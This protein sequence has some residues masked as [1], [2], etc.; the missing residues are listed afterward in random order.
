[1]AI[2]P[3]TDL[4]L[5]KVPINIDNQNQLTFAS[6]AAQYTYFNSLNK[7]EVDNFTYQ[8][9][10]GI[11]RYPAHIDSI[12]NY[13]YC[14]YQNSNY[15][16][17]WF[18]A[19]ITGM[20]YI[21][22]NMTEIAISTDVFQTWCFDIDVKT[23]YVEREHV[24][25]DS[26]GIHTIPE[27]LELGEYIVDNKI[28]RNLTS[29]NIIIGTTVDIDQPSSHSGK[30]PNIIGDIIGGV[31]TGV[32]YYEM[33]DTVANVVLER[34]A[35]KGQSDAVVT[36]FMSGDG[37]NDGTSCTNI[38][39]K[40][41]NNASPKTKTWS[42]L[43]VGG[44]SI[45]PPVKPTT[46]DTY[47]PVNKKLLTFPYCYLMA[48]NNSGN[49]AIY[50]Y[51]L[52]AP[53]EHNYCDFRFIGTPTPGMSIRLQPLNYNNQTV[54]NEEGLNVGKFP[55]CAWTNDAYT[56]WLTQNSVNIGLSI[57]SN[58]ISMVGGAALASTGA[59]AL[60]GAGAIVNGAMGI[61]NSL[62]QIYEHSLTPPQAEGNI[63]NGD[64]TFGAGLAGIT[65]YQMSIKQ[66]YAKIIDKYFT[67]FGYKVNTVKIPNV[68]GRT[69]WNYV[70]TID[71]NIEGYIPQTD[72]QAIKD[73]FNNG[74]TFWHNPTTFLDYSQ[75]NAIVS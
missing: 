56:N 75:T 30:Y 35:N 32:A 17:K 20:T 33:T 6:A 4:R 65:M 72:L 29:T 10:D 48:S 26:V 70:K 5:L 49:N 18:Y 59:G 61:A 54:N 9:K 16:D 71:V 13:N 40:R 14:M 53:E 36:M 39:A 34:L 12:I 51:E 24:N 57:G 19:F 43:V 73:M 46:L 15:T 50:K 66:E 38:V 47:E 7:L 31:Y 22:D 69:N 41:L 8:R 28:H 62:G 21:N 1:M 68:W 55:V 60:T 37:F 58:I 67:M 74:V 63:N 3:H 45:L 52:F 23:C 11:I 27:G 64:V 25:D 2:T 42:V 44:T